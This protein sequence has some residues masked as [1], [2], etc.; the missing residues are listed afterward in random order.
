MALEVTCGHCNAPLREC[1]VDKQGRAMPHALFDVAMEQL[2]CGDTVG[3]GVGV[4]NGHALFS[5]STG[6]HSP[7]A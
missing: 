4:E 5:R 2:P 1:L 7:C 6:Q 3:K